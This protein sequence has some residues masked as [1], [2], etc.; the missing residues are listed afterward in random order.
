MSMKLSI[1]A[2][3]LLS[4]SVVLLAILSLS[5]VYII[6]TA[7]SVISYVK[8]SRID[9]AA[10]TVG[11][12][13][14]VQLDRAG[15]DMVLISG[16]PTVQEGIALPS[17]PEGLLERSALS[18]L[19][20]RVS[21]AYGYYETL[22][23][24]DADARIVAITSDAEGRTLGPM[25]KQ[26]LAEAMDSY[27]FIVSTP[28]IST[29]HSESLLAVSLRFVYSGR[30]GALIGTLQLNKITA[31]ALRNASKEGV[32]P[33]VVDE[34]GLIVSAG[35]R[36]L[37]GTALTEGDAWFDSVKESVSGNLIAEL[38]GERKTIGFHHIP[39]TSLYAVVIADESYMKGYVDIIRKAAAGAGL[40]VSLLGVGCVVFFISPVT[41][42]IR[43]LSVFARRITEG[44]QGGET[45]VKRKDE[46]GDLAE[47]LGRMVVTLQDMLARSEAATVAKSEFL[48]R[49]SHEIRTPMNGIIGMTYLAMRDKPDEKQMRYL[50]RV[51]GAA[52][53][54]LGL[55]NDILDFSKMEAGKM[56]IQSYSFRLSGMLQS[57]YDLLSVKSAE[58]GLTMEFSVD[59]RVPDVLLGDSMRLSQVCL[60]ICSNALKFTHHGSILLNVSL[61]GAR[62]DGLM[63]LFG[64]KD[65]G[66]GMDQ[67]SLNG[68]F[69][70]FSQA[71]GSTTRKYGGT[72]LGLAISKTLV[73][74]MGGEIWVEST[75][76]EGST[77]FF[78]VLMREGVPDDVEGADA[79][80]PGEGMEPLPYTRALLA[81]D[82]EINQE[83]ASEILSDM[84]LEITLASNGAEALQLWESEDFDIILMDIQMPVMDGLTATRKIRASRKPGSREVPIIAMTANA[85]SGDR[86]K[87]LDAGMN[88]HVTKPLDVAEL[89]R[90]VSLWAAVARLNRQQDEGGVFTQGE[91]S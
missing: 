57:I 6:R 73:Q 11:N 68:I 52:K 16:L 63:L 5:T 74:M 20:R 3:L 27:N 13:V 84:G 23:L 77:F 17:G 34:S 44:G 45:G 81:E 37:V 88:D 71:D 25:E 47:S 33:Y 19:L 79:F 86:E 14:A 58:K 91:T 82:N 65:T 8:S 64:I 60:N 50:Q 4:I 42:D 56:E 43:Q 1:K 49:M 40:L 35:N 18:A 51:D 31:E 15:K 76:G 83:I 80:L 26:W 69:D 85:M 48:A 12:S 22:M 21:L 78:T 59:P 39:Q 29:D 53:S 75:P 67:E 66:I 55:I 72:G 41:R 10:K 46:L 9:D 7:Q 90:A 70:S 38:A 32:V 87:S 2:K 28:F 30:S 24:V 61:R 89:Y 54:L 36:G 62:S